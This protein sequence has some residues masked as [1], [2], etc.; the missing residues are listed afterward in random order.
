MAR[1]QLAQSDQAE[2][3]KVGL[4]FGETLGEERQLG[5]MRRHIKGDP[6]QALVEDLEDDSRA[7]EM[8]RALRQHRLTG[9]KRRINAR[10]DAN[11][12][13]MMLVA[14]IGECHEKTS[15]GD[16]LHLVKP[17]RVER[18]AASRTEPASRM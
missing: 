3:G 17:L 18:S 14:A 12:P 6:N 1:V 8:K 5:D 9:K 11:R 7:P 10:R 15:V 2:I 4:P 16:A 13:V